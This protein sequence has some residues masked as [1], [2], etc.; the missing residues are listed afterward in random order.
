M[1][2]YDLNR[3]NNRS[4]EQLV[5]ALAVDVFGPGLIIF[6]DG[7]DG[8]REATFDFKVPYPS[9]VDEWDG[10]CVVQAKFLQR[11][12]NTYEDGNWAVA[13]LKS[14]LEKYV[15]PDCVRKIPEYY[16]FVTNV[17]L[18]PV[19]DKGAKDRASALLEEYQDRLSLK[20]F[21]V[22]DY[23]KLRVFLDNNADVRQANE[24]WIT[25]GDVL[26]SITRRLDLEAQ[27]FR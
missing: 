24:A 1:P 17:V 5:Q 16:L 25:T 20:G 9:E 13:E 21:D 14:E 15:A 22:W 3:L 23:D 7:P 18:S 26:A 4:F 8:G 27:H 10:Y 11:P 12:K 6:G 19:Q 2:E